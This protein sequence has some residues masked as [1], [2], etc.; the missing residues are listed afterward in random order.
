MIYIEDILL[1]NFIID[2]LLLYTLNNLLKLNTKK[3]RIILSSLFGTI[4]LI[5]LFTIK[6]NLFLFITKL[7]ISIIM[8]LISFKYKNIKKLIKETV[9]FYIL[10]F[11]LGGIIFYL[12]TEEMISYSVIILLIPSIIKI[13]YKFEENLKETIKTKYKVNIYLNN[14]NILFLTGYMDSGNTLVEPYSNKKVIIINEKV[15]EKFFLV[16]YKTINSESLLKCFVPKR[17]YIE[18]IG[19]RNDIVVGISNL[20]MNNF[21][22]LLNYKLMEEI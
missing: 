4:S 3:I 5:L 17:V 20:K 22:C 15:D 13:Y 1:L 16:P 14:G 18:N 8:V 6:N 11:F 2:Y 21:D 19:E 9:Y 10:S 12:K 7:I